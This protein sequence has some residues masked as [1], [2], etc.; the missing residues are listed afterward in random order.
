MMLYFCIG[1]LWSCLD[2][3]QGPARYKLAALPTELQLQDYFSC[4]AELDSASQ[5][6]VTIHTPNFEILNQVQDDMGEYNF[7]FSDYTVVCE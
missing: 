3:N 5:P 1:D 6:Y 4:H 7:N 2:S